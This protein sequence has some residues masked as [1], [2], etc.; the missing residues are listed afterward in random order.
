MNLT[1]SGDYLVFCSKFNEIL[2]NLTFRFNFSENF[3]E[4][5]R[6]LSRFNVK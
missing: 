2:R 5:L 6:D 1:Y 4:N 3:V